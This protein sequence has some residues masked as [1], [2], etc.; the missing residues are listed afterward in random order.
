MLAAILPAARSHQHV[1]TLASHIAGAGVPQAVRS[2]PYH[3]QSPNCA[4]QSQGMQNSP[5][6][7]PALQLAVSLQE[8]PGLT[9]GFVWRG[10]P[11]NGL[12]SCT[13]PE[14]D[15][16]QGADESSR[17]SLSYLKKGCNC[18][19]MKGWQKCEFYTTSSIF[20]IKI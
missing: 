5:V 18:Q 14:Q 20:S 12:C 11:P 17:P 3:R 7:S 10:T 9:L 8:I 15:G 13:V 19:K 6:G 2:A 16:A 1:F 4:E